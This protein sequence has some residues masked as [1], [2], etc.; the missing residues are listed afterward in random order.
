MMKL[1]REGQILTGIRNHLAFLDHVLGFDALL[2]GCGRPKGF[3]P[4]HCPDDPLDGS[5]V[6]LN[7]NV[8][9]T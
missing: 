8:S 1:F 4:E 2:G 9:G 5:M 7:Q 3:E 6:L